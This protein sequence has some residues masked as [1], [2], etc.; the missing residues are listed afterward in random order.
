MTV[1]L[2]ASAVVARAD[3]FASSYEVNTPLE[4]LVSVTVM[5]P[6]SCP[7][8]ALVRSG[9]RVVLLSPLFWRARM[10]SPEGESRSS[11]SMQL[12]SHMRSASRCD[13]RLTAAAVVL[14]APSASPYRTVPLSSKAL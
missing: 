6:S 8:V 10:V 7:P 3:V 14:A 2:P 5:R 1:P 11:F 9:S 4:T 12:S 13:A